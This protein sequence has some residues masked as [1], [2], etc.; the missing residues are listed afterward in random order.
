M[1]FQVSG[2]TLHSSYL[3][4]HTL[5]Y[6]LFTVSCSRENKSQMCRQMYSFNKMKKLKNE[7]F[8][9]SSHDTYFLNRARDYVC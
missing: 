5:I 6:S 8:E 3:K 4:I 7:H 1:T 2:Q 9:L